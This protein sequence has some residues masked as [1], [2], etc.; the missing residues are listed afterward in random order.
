MMTELIGELTLLLTRD[1]SQRDQAHV[2]PNLEP[3]KNRK[4]VRLM[5]EEPSTPEQTLVVQRFWEPLLGADLDAAARLPQLASTPDCRN[6]EFYSSPRLVHADAIAS[7][8]MAAASEVQQVEADAFLLH[9]PIGT[10]LGH[11]IRCGIRTADCLTWLGVW[12]TPEKL[13]ITGAHLGWRSFAAG[14]HFRLIDAI[15]TLCPSA[16]SFSRTLSHGSCH[17]FGPT[18]FGSE[19]PCRMDDVGQKLKDL[20]V[21]RSHREAA[22]PLPNE[23]FGLATFG[24]LLRPHASAKGEKCF[25]DLQLLCLLDLIREGIPVDHVLL[26][27]VNTAT[28]SVYPSHRWRHRKQGPETPVRLLSQV[29]VPSGQPLNCFP[30]VH[31]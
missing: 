24:P 17:Y 16:A 21:K 14:L 25:P 9:A 26:H 5:H 19:Y 6:V 4:L 13:L 31:H 18:V 20:E 10:Q 27:R 28:S 7:A 15:R 22:V 29:L 11:D 12:Q 2:L 23:A 3:E 30:D 8:P 1:H